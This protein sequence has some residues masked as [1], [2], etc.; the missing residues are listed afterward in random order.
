MPNK[1]EEKQEALAIYEMTA[2]KGWEALKSIILERIAR[3]ISSLEMSKFKHL[4]EVTHI[5]GSMESLRELLWYVE[6]RVK[7]V[8]NNFED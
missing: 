2:S 8:E 1:D 6:R 3:E 5:Q 4:H 7:K